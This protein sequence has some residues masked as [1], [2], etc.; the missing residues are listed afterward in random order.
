MAKQIEYNA[1]VTSRIEINPFLIILGVTTDQPFAAFKP[2]QYATLALK[3]S[4]PRVHNSTPE[5]NPKEGDVAIQRAYSIASANTSKELEFYLALVTAGELTP[6]LF[7]L[8]VGDPVYVSAKPVG[9]FTLERV[10]ENKSVLFMATGTGLAP[11]ISMLR[12]QMDVL[13][14]KKVVVLHG[15]R[16]SGDLGYREELE[17]LAKKHSNIIY[18]PAISQPAKDP[19]WKGLSGYLQDVLFSGEVEK[20]TGVK[21]TPDNF[22]VFICGNPAMIEAAIAKLSVV[23]FI[24]AKGKTPGTIHIEEYW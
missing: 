4:A 5:A 19:S 9:L 1:K 7:A 2:G 8:Q 10:Q 20:R 12:S 21:V 11:Y 14:N 6:R 18:M 17:E 22:D 23:G 16:H 24:L 13:K 15:V 3:A